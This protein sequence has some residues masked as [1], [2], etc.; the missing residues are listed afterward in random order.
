V[1]DAPFSET[2]ELS[3]QNV[4]PSIQNLI[5]VADPPEKIPVEE[6]GQLEISFI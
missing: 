4:V 3:I 2:K 1:S 5:Q 6:M